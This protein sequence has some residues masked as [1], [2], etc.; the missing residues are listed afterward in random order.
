MTLPDPVTSKLRILLVE[1]HPINRR[2]LEGMLALQG[3]RTDAAGD[4]AE[5][6]E[7]FA[8]GPY[9]LVFMDSHMPG[10]DGFEC[11][12]RLRALAPSP[13]PVIIGVTGDADAESRVRCLEAGMDDM[14]AKPIRDKD[15]RGAVARWFPANRP[16]ENAPGTERK[17]GKDWIDAAQVREMKEWIVR[18]NPAYFDQALHQFEESFTRLSDKIRE[19]GSLGRFR[20]AGESAHALKGICLTMGMNRMA[21]ICKEL[22][23]MA[24]GGAAARWT[25]NLDRL[26]EAH[27]PSVDEWRRL[28]G[29]V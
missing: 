20:E 28:A 13:R 6:L 25:E 12:R 24:L 16:A 7:A 19:A 3:L 11:A 21:E 8:R 14:I 1:D 18:Y 17:D 23:A 4:G 15:L 29:V 2:V 9:D 26:G 5:A 27:G 10:M 22:E